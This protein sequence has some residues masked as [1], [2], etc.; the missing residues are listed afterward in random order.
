MTAFTEPRRHHKIEVNHLDRLA[1]VYVRQSTLAQLQHHQES[2]RLQ[3]AL[4]HHAAELGWAPDRVLVID[5]D[6]GKS[7][8]TATG[9]PGFTR[10]VTEVS[11]GHVGLILG[12]EMSRL[13]RSNRDWHHLLEVCALFQT[14]IGDAD[15]IYNPA[16]YNDRLLLGLKGTMSEAEL[17]ILKN[18][19]HQGK[20]NKARRGELG[21]TMPTGYIRDAYGEIQMDPDEQV[22]QVIQL[23]FRKFEELG[24]VHAL[25]RYLVEHQVQLGVRERTRA[26]GGRLT[27]RRPNRMTLQNLLHNPIYAGVYAYGR[28]QVDPRKKLAGYSSTGRVSLPPDQWHVLL[29]DHLPA[30]ITWDQYQEHVAR[31]AANR[32]VGS[33]SGAPKRGTGLL[34]GLLIC[35]RCGHRMVASYH[36]LS[37]GPAVRYSC[38]RDVTDYGGSPCFGCA[39]T[40]VD[41]WV[42]TQ[43][44]EALTPAGVALSLEAQSSLN[45][46]REALDRHWHARLEWAQYEAARAARQYQGVEPEHRLVARSLERAWEEA[47][48]AERALK[49]EYDRHVQR[50]PRQLTTEEIRQ[51][52]LISTAL[53]A[54]WSASTTTM[55]DRKEILRLVIQRVTVWGDAKNEHMDVRIEWQGDH[56]T[57]G[58]VIRP[59]ARCDQV[60]TYQEVCQRVEAGVRE[61]KTALEVADELN[62]AGWRPPKRRATWNVTQ[63]R[64]LAQRLGLQFS[65]GTDGRA[66]RSR[67]P[68]RAGDWWTL[69]GLAQALEM[70]AVTLYTWLRR[71]V[72]N[73]KQSTRGG[74]WRLWADDAEVRR[75]QALRSEPVGARYHQRWID[76]ATSMMNTQ[77]VRDVS[78]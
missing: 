13:A 58:H 26:G 22:Q 31:L 62:A 56:V 60:S 10:L 64:G 40:A 71:G 73:G 51:V 49:E 15:G 20:L 63:V 28:R 2:T 24:T 50:Q 3:Y 53:P 70:P 69:P 78:P 43:L 77:E 33:W 44:L 37:T 76:K 39:G 34:S 30:Y 36:Q 42:V 11:L 9:R 21:I 72:V 38:T 46:D 41:R 17:H 54:L 59:V 1:I 29:K 14:L 47:L 75:L 18:R 25:L 55:Q 27:W 57:E 8:T 7:G 4:V 68:P 12:I 45:R 48:E 74:S 52:Q 67:L 16:D 35:G 32:N 5:D 65:K 61:G 6:Q 19:M 66:V 23:I